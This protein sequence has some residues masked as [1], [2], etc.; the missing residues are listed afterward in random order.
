M[1]KSVW[2]CP[3]FNVFYLIVGFF[4]FGRNTYLRKLK[5]VIYIRRYYFAITSSARF[6]AAL[7]FGWKFS[8][9]TRFVNPALSMTFIGCSLT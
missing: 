8:F 5:K 9:P 3:F 1:G 2:A 6:K 7:I 4:R